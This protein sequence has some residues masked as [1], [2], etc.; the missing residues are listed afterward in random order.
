VGFDNL[1]FYVLVDT[2]FDGLLE[3][4]SRGLKKSKKYKKSAKSCGEGEHQI[5]IG[6]ASTQKVTV[7]TL[8]TIGVGSSYLT[9]VPTYISKSKPLLGSLLF[10]NNNVTFNFTEDKIRLSSY[11]NTEV[12]ISSYGVGLGLNENKAVEI[13]FIWKDSEAYNQGLR[14]GQI[15]SKISGVDVSSISNDDL[16]ALKTEVNEIGSLELHY[17]DKGSEKNIS[18]NK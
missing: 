5:T 2:G 11:R 10:K 4:N 7:A 12:N 17:L 14:I 1:S 18:L 13:V 3:L 9:N 8:D 16:C 6:G 15:I